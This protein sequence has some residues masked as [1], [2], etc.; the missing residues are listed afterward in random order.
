MP[1]FTNQQQVERAIQIMMTALRTDLHQLRERPSYELYTHG[2]TYTIQRI[3]VETG[4]LEGQ[5]VILIRLLSTWPEWR[6]SGLI[7]QEAL[8]RLGE[9][10]LV[11]GNLI[12]LPT[13]QPP[14]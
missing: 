7:I 13:T 14:R 5:D 6:D 3:A 8:R 10:C 11:E 12:M 2:T 9:E 4:L 1:W